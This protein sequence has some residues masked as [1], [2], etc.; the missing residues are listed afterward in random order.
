MTAF[1]RETV[2][3][4]CV[5]CKRRVYWGCCARPVKPVLTFTPMGPIVREP[6]PPGEAPPVQRMSGEVNACC[7]C[8]VENLSASA[9]KVSAV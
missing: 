7:V 6:T 8:L 2:G 9:V 3:C 1:T 4:H 5:V